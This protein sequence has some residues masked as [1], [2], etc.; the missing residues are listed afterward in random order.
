MEDVFP[1]N[2]HERD[3]VHEIRGFAGSDSR[4]ERG[5][6]TDFISAT[7]GVGKMVIP[8]NGWN[9]NSQCTYSVNRRAS[10]GSSST[11]FFR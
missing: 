1:S 3:L 2:K 4:K 11:E 8:T 5:K 10:N 9:I 7:P 6:G